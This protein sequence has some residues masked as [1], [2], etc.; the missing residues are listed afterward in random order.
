MLD[1]GSENDSNKGGVNAHPMRNDGRACQ[2][3]IRANTLKLTSVVWVRGT[4]TMRMRSY[5][6]FSARDQRRKKFADLRVA[7]VPA[8]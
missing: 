4:S 1:C 3:I 7:V 5:I 6:E 2:A 8:L